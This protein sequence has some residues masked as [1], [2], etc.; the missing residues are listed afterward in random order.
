M[1]H[2][3]RLVSAAVAAAV[4]APLP[5]W[6]QLEEV[7]VTARKRE[8]SILKVPV[9]ATVLGGAALE[10]YES[11]DLYNITERVPGLNF[12]AGTLSFGAQVS[13][14]GVGTSVLNA[15]LD[16]SIAL[17]IDGMQM[18]Q[19]LSYA[20]G[21]F[22]SSQ[23]EVLKGPQALFY[24]KAAP[25]GVI[26]I[27]T[28]DPGDE[29]ELIARYGYEVEAEEDRIDLIV[30]G[31]ITDT[32]GVR[33]SGRMSEL[34][35][36]RKNKGFAPDDPALAFGG[37]D[38]AEKNFAPKED[39]MFRATA[40]WEPTERFAA[41][42]KFNYMK[43]ELNGDAYATD[44][45]SCPDGIVGPFGFQFINPND[46]CKYDKKI[47]IVDVDPDVFVGVRNN[48]TPFNDMNQKFTTVDLSYEL[49]DNWTID[50]VTGY[51]DL[52]QDSMINGH[53]S[54]YLGP[55]IVA[56][57]GFRR[58]DWTQELRLTSNYSGAWN[59]MFGAFYQDSDIEYVNNL[60][61]NPSLGLPLQLNEGYQPIGIESTSLFGQVLWD[62][63]PN[64]ELAAGV[65]WTD[66][67]RTHEVVSTISGSP[68]IVP[69]ATPKLATDDYSPELTATWTPT[70]TFTVFASYKE[71]FKAG[72][73][74]TVTIP[75]PGDEKSFDDEKVKGYEVGF[76]S[77]LM[78]RQLAFNAALYYYEFSDMQ[79]GSNI[80]SPE[81]AIIITTNN[82]AS[83]EITGVDL[84][85]TYAPA[86]VDGLTV[87]GALNYNQAEYDKFDTAPCWGGQLIQDGC[88]LLFDETT[89]DYSAQD[90]SGEQ[91]L[92]A[93]ELTGV[94]GVDYAFPVGQGMQVSMGW[95]TS[96]SDEYWVN[97]GYR[98]PDMQWD[99]YWTHNANIALHGPDEAWEIALIANNLEDEQVAG[100][101]SNSNYQ[102]GVVFGGVNTGSSEPGV[103][104]IEELTC[105]VINRRSLWIRFSMDF[106]QFF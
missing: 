40:K 53:S 91:L 85:F 2:C 43:S 57:P 27:T 51:F 38:P 26:A 31:P 72:S 30:S 50:S 86:N 64:L 52:N 1:R 42:V 88:N 22:D 87:Y 32:L 56:D 55:T 63:L 36:F 20:I 4:F 34:E 12:S 21:M 101:C 58:E 76:K 37:V 49:T 7:I 83:S 78:D 95:Y 79:V 6:A 90:L 102:N 89:G 100:Q 5:V 84:D 44:F 73:F 48:G 65:R 71:A 97:T 15:T 17:N 59:F 41:R 66:E 18:T 16:Q 96:Y 94:I 9:V 33:L 80:N 25:G 70:D 68:V 74:D 3:K 99:S 24:G 82:A 28:E 106:A 92:R 81:G 39:V 10:Q 103:A 45:Y 8:E 13:L 11:G 60:L 54:G 77:E 23:V 47:Y 46:N 14:R 61:G 62:V 75:A 69:T 105:D 98:R 104:G 35:G 93:P 67:E 29:L 19:G